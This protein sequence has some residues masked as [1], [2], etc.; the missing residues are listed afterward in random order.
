MKLQ[1]EAK[2]NIKYDEPLAKYSTWRV[3]GKADCLY[4][5]QSLACLRK[6]LQTLDK[7]IPI[8][9]LGLGSNLLIRDNGI[10]GLVI[11][12]QG[13]LKQIHLVDGDMVDV[14]VGVSCASMARFCARNDLSGGEFWAGIPGT[15]GGAL[16]MNA[17]CFNGETW[18][19]LVF[20][21]VMDRQGNIRRLEKKDFTISYRHIQGL[22]PDEWFVSARFKLSPGDKQTSMAAIKS[23]LARRAETQPAG[24]YNCGSV[25]RNPDGM[26]A[27]Q[28]IEACGL[29]GHSIGDAEV[30]PKH[31]NFINNR[32]QATAK[33]IESLIHFIQQTV[34]AEKGITLQPE[35]HILG[36][37]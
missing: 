29:K 7:D 15:M 4:K 19:H 36:Q 34:K 21:D 33:D 11:L 2:G 30:S 31:A 6:T 18:D 20:V 12:T 27:A 8:V 1:L 17:G 14:E 26:Y 28:L 13:A 24:E 37:K 16:R 23:L 9:W 35:V 3:G 22:Q 32:G 5:P 25:F 10:R